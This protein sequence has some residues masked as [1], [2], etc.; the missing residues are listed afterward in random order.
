MSKLASTYAQ[1]LYDLAKAEDLTDDVLGELCTVRDVFGQ[2]PDYLRLLTAP[3][4]PKAERSGLLQES[5]GGKVHTYVLNFLKILTEKGYIRYFSDCC[6]A[7]ETLYNAD[8]GI[9][10]VQAVTA[11]KLSAEQ[12]E[13]LT[14]KLSQIT[15]KTVRLMVRVDPKCL[16][17]VRLLY[18]GKLVEGT[19]EGRLRAVRDMLMHTAL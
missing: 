1:A 18:D 7:F 14:D 5:L 4:I 3:N 16:G 11:V 2:Q 15:G 13:R 6:K 9:L 10:P 17:G 8:H 19:V 12:E